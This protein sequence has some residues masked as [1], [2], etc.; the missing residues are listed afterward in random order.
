MTQ[1]CLIRIVDDDEDMRESLS[2][3]LESEG[4]KCSAYSS[5]REF[6]IEDAGSVPGCLILDIR[7]DGLRAAAGNESKKNFSADRFPHGTRQ[8]RYGSFR[9]EIRRS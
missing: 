8:Y 5:A 4:W 3:L 6:L 7:D 1:G 9:H 2:F